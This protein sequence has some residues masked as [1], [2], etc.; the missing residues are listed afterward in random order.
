M[1]TARTYIS[2]DQEHK[3]GNDPLVF[4]PKDDRTP[5]ADDVTQNVLDM[6]IS[7]GSSIFHASGVYHYA[8]DS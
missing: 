2:E 5:G 7:C 8:I 4:I 6:E 1:N 3:N